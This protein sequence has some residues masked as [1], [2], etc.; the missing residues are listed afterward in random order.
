MNVAFFATRNNPI[1]AVDGNGL[2]LGGSWGE[3]TQ[4]TINKP[5]T[6]NNDK[7]K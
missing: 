4:N 6:L 5:K 7:T 1:L 2:Q 3:P